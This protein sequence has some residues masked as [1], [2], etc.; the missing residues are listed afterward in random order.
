MQS[1]SH[2]E[3]TMRRNI[4]DWVVLSNIF[5]SHPI[6][7]EMIQFDEHIFQMGW[8]NHQLK[9]ERT[10]GAPKKQQVH[11]TIGMPCQQICIL[12]M[13][14]P[15]GAQLPPRSAM[16]FQALDVSKNCNSMLNAFEP[17]LGCVFFL[18]GG[19]CSNT[20]TFT[21]LCALYTCCES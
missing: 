18:G 17:G 15:I 9:S 3:K 13:L 10:L 4:K 11:H 1:R 6:C 14:L 12:N 20:F 7:G 19:I 16:I 8:F 2:V 21:C 5:Y